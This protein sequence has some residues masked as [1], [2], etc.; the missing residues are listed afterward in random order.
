MPKISH[1]TDASKT[2]MPVVKANA[3]QCREPTMTEI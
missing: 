2:G 3:T 1:G